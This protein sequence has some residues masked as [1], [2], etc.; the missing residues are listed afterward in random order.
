MKA[1]LAMAAVGAMTFSASA[2]DPVTLYGDWSKAPTASWTDGA[3]NPVSWEDGSIARITDIKNGN[4]TV[5]SITAYGLV[6]DY[7]DRIGF[8]TDNGNVTVGAGGITFLQ[9][10]SYEFG[11]N[12]FTGFKLLRISA[13]QT[14]SGPAEGTAYAN[15]GLGRPTF[16][17]YW[18]A[19]LVVDAAVTELGICG[20]LNVWFSSPS[21]DLSGV[22][23]TVTA[24]ARVYLPYDYPADSRT[25]DAQ[26]RA[27]SLTLSGEGDGMLPLGGTVANYT[28]PN[29]KLSMLRSLDAGHLAPILVLKDGA[30]LTAA[31]AVDFA[32]PSVTVD[33]GESVIS[34]PFV[35]KQAETSVALA[36][37]AVLALAGNFTE[38]G[39]SAALTVT[40]TGTLIVNTD[41]YALSGA[42]TL[43]P[44]VALRLTGSRAGEFRFTGGKS[45]TITPSGD[46]VLYLSSS[47]FE[48]AGFEKVA[49]TTGTVLLEDRSFTSR[50]DGDCEI[51]YGEDDLLIVTDKVRTE[52]AITVEKNKPLRI[53]GNGLTAGT[54]LTFGGGTNLV[55]MR[56]ATVSSS[57]AMTATAIVCCGDSS[58]IGTISGAVTNPDN[59][60]QR[61]FTVYGP[62][63]I[64]LSGGWSLGNEG[65]F[66]VNYEGS[67]TLTGDKEYKTGNWSMSCGIAA[68]N[69][70]K[71]N[72]RYLGV[73]D[74]ARLTFGENAGTDKRDIFDLAPCLNGD[75][76]AT[77]TFEVGPGG[78]VE[79]PARAGVYFGGNQSFA[80]TVISGGTVKIRKN[81]Y[82]C[83]AH[84]GYSHGKLNLRAGTLEL[85]SPIRLNESTDN[86]FVEWTG[87]T[88]KIAA[89]FTGDSLVS[90]VFSS[91]KNSGDPVVEGSRRLAFALNGECTI[92]LSECPYEVFTNM[93]DTTNRGEWYGTGTLVVKGGKTLLMR[94]MPD[95]VGVRVEGDGTKVMID[96]KTRIFD[97]EKCKANCVFRRPYNSSKVEYSSAEAE[98]SGLHLTAFTLA[99]GAGNMENADP[100]RTVSVDTAVVAEGGVWSNVST[101]LDDGIAFG[102]LEFLVGSVLSAK[103]AGNVTPT[104]ALTGALK[105]ADGEINLRVDR[106]GEP[107][108]T[109]LTV[110]TAAGGIS[111]APTWVSSKK[112]WTAEIDGDSLLMSFIG[113]GLMLLFK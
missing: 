109:D 3:G 5:P 6:L 42:V 56:S 48:A 60:G 98:V 12:L 85:A 31:S 104:R 110:F 16:S 52:T 112:S 91:T 86:S 17:S 37:D 92:D 11:R 38:E 58:V 7:R 40:G 27:K 25:F 8:W 39:V 62:G 29:A 24:P 57:I 106:D 103:V 35:V 63:S 88:I 36:D 65:G 76:N 90:G 51:V 1:M 46:G 67:L 19:P 84:G 21:N 2:E 94:S 43:G 30:D 97:N 108:G 77:C 74:G 93:T 14:W 26:I 111:G 34:G 83:L 66:K 69:T 55:F 78:T 96:S 68:D 64:V 15:L 87:G 99:N 44:D 61:A 4:A 72:G 41:G 89:D 81:S 107:A 13:N 47:F 70:K 33:G 54:A 71:T 82:F 113:K 9:D 50:V 22:D 18:Q 49:V 28:S 100:V 32:I 10:G 23:V 102:D 105:L 53:Y 79:F 73:R 101:L 75:Y 59:S 95:S 80:Q 45:L 20:H